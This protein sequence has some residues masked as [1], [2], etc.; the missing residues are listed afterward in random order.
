M[1]TNASKVEH[2]SYW[3]FKIIR[4]TYLLLHV[5]LCQVHVVTDLTKRLAI[6]PESRTALTDAAVKHVFFFV[7]V[8]DALNVPC[9]STTIAGYST[10]TLQ[11]T[12]SY[13]AQ[14]VM[15]VRK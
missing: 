12:L 2:L 3:I 8:R 13:N 10:G 14:H 1:D 11:G 9:T 6:E 5:V 15:D 4:V 7:I